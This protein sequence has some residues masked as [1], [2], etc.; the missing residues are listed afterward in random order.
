MSERARR[1]VVVRGGVQGVGYRASCAWRAQTLG[2]AGWVRNRADG[3]VEAVF[4]GADE[5]V[6]AMVR[7][8]RGGPPM[9]RVGVVD[10]W[11]EEAE[12]IEGFTVR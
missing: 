1:R 3:S 8:C 11:P 4:E 10:V 5:L 6:D 9:A 7:W 12:G 2:V